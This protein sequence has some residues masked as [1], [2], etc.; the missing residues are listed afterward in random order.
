MRRLVP[1]PHPWLAPACHLGRLLPGQPHPR[2]LPASTNSPSHWEDT[3][4]SP[5]GVTSA[6]CSSARPTKLLSGDT[7]GVTCGRTTRLKVPRSP[8]REPKPHSQ[9]GSAVQQSHPPRPPR[10]SCPQLSCC[11]QRGLCGRPWQT[12]SE[13]PGRRARSTEQQGRPHAPP[14]PLLPRSGPCWQPA[15]KGA[16]LPPL[17]CQGRRRSRTWRRRCRC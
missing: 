16:S 2:S 1:A 9:D 5:I 10:P 14:S 13:L 3:R 17:Q 6:S 8:G 4:L 7:A 15:G 12:C 11:A